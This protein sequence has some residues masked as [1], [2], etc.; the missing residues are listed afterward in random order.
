MCN[1][2][3]LSCSYKSRC[4]DIT[5][6]Y[7][8]KCRFSRNDNAE[9]QGVCDSAEKSSGG[10][11]RRVSVC[12]D[13]TRNNRNR[14]TKKSK[15]IDVDQYKDEL[16]ESY[17]QYYS[18][19]WSTSQREDEESGD[20]ADDSGEDASLGSDFPTMRDVKQKHRNFNKAVKRK[21][22][23]VERLPKR[24]ILINQKP[25][26][27][28]GNETSASSK[29]VQEESRRGNGTVETTYEHLTLRTD[30]DLKKMYLSVPIESK[31][32]FQGFCNKRRGDIAEEEVLKK[33]E[34]WGRDRELNMFM[35]GGYEYKSFLANLT[36]IPINY[37]EAKKL[38][39]QPLSVSPSKGLSKLLTKDQYRTWCLGF[40]QASAVVVETETI[41]STN[42][43]M[44]CLFM[45][46]EQESIVCNKST[47]ALIF[48]D[49]GTGKSLVQMQKALSLVNLH[50][51]R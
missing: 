44:T 32:S 20:S 7:I 22:N 38:A 1:G 14:K 18:N 41:K 45:N 17:F 46:P 21:L 23:E 31:P 10:D 48:G 11:D 9:S 37:L 27:Q 8:P 30:E 33:F 5:N 3:S 36:S 19:L 40:G 29:G 43:K 4:A 25:V 35:F 49:Y 15:E 12:K 16:L 26:E 51:Q 28:S 34:E 24:Q 6:I 47:Q 42:N 39:R 2:K 50:Y 13:V